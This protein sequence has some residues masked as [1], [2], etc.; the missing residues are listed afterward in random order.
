MKKFKIMAL[1]P[2]AAISIISE[3]NIL[4]WDGVL[5]FQ[6]WRGHQN[7]LRSIKIRAATREM[8]AVK[9]TM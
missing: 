1:H 5:E 9:Q 6:T 2:K 7:K 4:I 3:C 8:I